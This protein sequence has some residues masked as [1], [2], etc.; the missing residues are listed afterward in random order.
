MYLVDTS[1]WID[2][3]NGRE[4]E[5]VALLD[6]LLSNPLAVGITDLVYM[7][8][9][10]GARDQQHFDRFR[11]YFS[12]LRFYRPVAAEPTHAAAAQLFLDCRRHGIAVRST[13]DC[14][15]AQCAI[16][17]DLILLHH[18]RDFE[19]MSLVRKNLR[20]RHFLP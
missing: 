12:G 11:R 1:A 8:I 7:E 16:D 10:Q 14:L 5:H 20:Q 17:H 13:V 19:R 15:I 2:Y 9:L 4:A 3:L 18:D 6:E